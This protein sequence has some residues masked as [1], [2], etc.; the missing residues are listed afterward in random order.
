M[1]VG[2]D[3]GG[4][5][6]G[7]GTVTAD[8]MI[9]NKFEKNITDV[10]R[11]DIKQFLIQTIVSVVKQWITEDGITVDKIGIGVPGIVKDDIVMYSVNLGINNYDLKGELQQHF[12]DIEI[13]IKND[14]KCAALAEKNFGAL[15][16]YEDCI[17]ICLGTGIGGAAFYKN[18]LIIPKRSSGFEFGHMILQKDGVSCRCGSQGCFEIYGSMRRFKHDIREVLNVDKSVEGKELH[19]LIKQKM[20]SD[21]VKNVI[22]GYIENLCIGISNVIDV[23]EPEAICIGGSFAYYEDVML[24]KLREELCGSKYIFYKDNMPEIMVA[25][26]GNDAGIIGSAIYA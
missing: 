12:P 17:F 3:I 24:D 18:N 23:L 22:N 7:I 6:I 26:T 8:G 14:A 25:T 16:N 20:D 2:I 13:H 10:E 11:K 19:D 21:Y 9:H 5:H 1:H 4:S 15:R